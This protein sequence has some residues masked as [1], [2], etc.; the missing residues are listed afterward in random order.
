MH[1]L[2]SAVRDYRQAE[3]MAMQSRADPRGIGHC[4]PGIEAAIKGMWYAVGQEMGLNDDRSGFDQKR[5]NRE[6][7]WVADTSLL[8]QMIDDWV[9]QDEDRDVRLT[10]VLSGDWTIE[11]AAQLYSETCEICAG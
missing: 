8:M 10:P 5:W 4:W 1:V 9:D 11:S 6:Q 7:K 2:E 3:A